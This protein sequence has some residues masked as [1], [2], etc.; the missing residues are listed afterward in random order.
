MASQWSHGQQSTITSQ[1]MPTNI[2]HLLHGTFHIMT[3]F[4]SSTSW[5]LMLRFRLQFHITK[6]G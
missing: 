3:S 1:M 6:K 2:I 4:N 5:S